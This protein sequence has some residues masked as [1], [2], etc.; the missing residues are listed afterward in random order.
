M[1]EFGRTL[2]KLR[3]EAGLNQRELAEAAG[4]ISKGTV[5]AVE[6]AERIPGIDTVLSMCRPLAVTPDQVLR[7]A[8]LIPAEGEVQDEGFWELWGVWKRL[9]AGERAALMD[10]AVFQ[11][12]RRG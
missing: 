3:Q 12:G 7:R 8:G 5:S 4:G 6:R 10:F 1:E 2:R 11:E 9:T